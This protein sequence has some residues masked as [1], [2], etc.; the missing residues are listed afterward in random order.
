M[1]VPP[2][3]DYRDPLMVLGGV[4]H[5][6]GDLVLMLKNPNV[7]SGAMCFGIGHCALIARQIRLGVR[8]KYPL[9]HALVWASAAPLIRDPRLI[10]YAG[11]LTAYSSFSA[12]WGGPLF[13]LSDVFVYLNKRFPHKILDA[14]AIATYGS[15]QLLLF[16]PNVK[17][18]LQVNSH[19]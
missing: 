12:S 10:T 9:V 5:T 16:A 7:Y 2:L 19:G 18:N 4:G 1:I 17:A 13:M 11:V 15:A 14:V 6:L 8:P 3:L